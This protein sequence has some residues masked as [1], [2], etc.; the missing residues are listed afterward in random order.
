VANPIEELKLASLD[1]S[2]RVYHQPRS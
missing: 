2:Q 1:Q